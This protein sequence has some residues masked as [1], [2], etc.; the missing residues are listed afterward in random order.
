MQLRLILRI[1]TQV[2]GAKVDLIALVVQPA[3][4]VAKFVNL[5][6]AE[7]LG[8]LEVAEDLAAIDHGP[9]ID[10]ALVTIVPHA[11]ENAMDHWLGGDNAGML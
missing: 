10:H 6:L 3:D 11:L 4:R 9:E 5:E 2:I 7:V 1:A 8:V